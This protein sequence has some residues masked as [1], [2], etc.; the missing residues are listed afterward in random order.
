MK[1]K[2]AAYALAGVLFA[3]GA[4]AMANASAKTGKRMDERMMEQKAPKSM[5]GYQMIPGPEGLSYSYKM[6]QS[7]Y[8]TLK[9]YGIVAQTFTDGRSMFDVVLI[10]SDNHESFHDPKICF[11][12]QGWTF[13]S[14]RQE[15]IDIGAGRQIP[16]TVVEM[17][18]PTGQSSAIYFYKGPVGFRSKP[19]ALQLDMFKEVL[20]GHKPTD[21]TFYRFMPSS[22][23]VTLEQLK[24]F[25][26]TYMVSAAEESGGFF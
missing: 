10:S 26:K 17:Q 24:G 11:S 1:P 14:T 20:V 22:P 12:G 16:A 9:P 18:G 21:S 8:D 2:V 13:D 19:Q 7:T 6:P 15:T 25:I 23:G 3:S 4:F 5:A